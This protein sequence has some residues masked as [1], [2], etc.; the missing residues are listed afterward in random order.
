MHFEKGVC[1]ELLDERYS[2]EIKGFSSVYLKVTIMH[3]SLE[4]ANILDTIGGGCIL[5]RGI[6]YG[7]IHKLL[8]APNYF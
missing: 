8:F 6:V 7:C 2:N 4:N 1:I 5:K 3:T